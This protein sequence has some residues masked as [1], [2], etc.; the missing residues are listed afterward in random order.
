MD[1]STKIG[2]ERNKERYIQRES[3]ER[4]RKIKKEREKRKLGRAGELDKRERTGKSC[5]KNQ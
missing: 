1:E 2:R 3:K 4:E 5:R